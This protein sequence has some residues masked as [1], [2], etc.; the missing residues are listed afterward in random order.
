MRSTMVAILLVI[1]SSLPFSV[2]A[3][4][5]A[6]P[7]VALLGNV[8]FLSATR[9]W[10][11]VSTSAGYSL[12][13]YQAI[14]E[15]A[16]CH[17]AVTDIY[18]TANGGRTW[19]RI[20]RFSSTP[21]IGTA[22]PVA[23]LHAFDAQHILVVPTGFGPPRPLYWTVDGGRSWTRHAP[24][25]RLGYVTNGDIAS[26]G[27]HNLWMLVE[28]GAAMGSEQVTVYRSRDT[29]ARWIRAACT[30]FSTAAAA[31]QSS[32]LGIYGFKGGI[33]FTGP[34]T[35][36][37]VD[38]NNSG[39]PYLYATHDGGAHWRIERL[40]L[41]R[42][43]PAPNAAAD[44]FPYVTLAQ[45][46]FFGADGVLPATANVCRGHRSHGHT[47]YVCRSEFSLLLSKDRGLTWPI[48]RRLPLETSQLTSVVHQFLS[49]RT[50]IVDV[51]TTLRVTTDAG[52]HWAA[53]APA[54]IP[55]GYS[56]MTL[57]FVTRTN[58]WVIAARVYRP[59]DLAR[60]TL[61]MHTV[62]GGQDWQQVVVP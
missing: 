5:A 41:P 34:S 56:L 25:Q 30:A 59:D 15:P 60:S 43:V 2:L 16:A 61:L 36:F 54:G 19:R 52:R 22:L 8:T 46:H 26:S 3:S 38:N 29:G 53:I 11:E 58:G 40:G 4:S 49:A 62:D 21:F 44:R 33:V 47:N 13:C 55:H 17:R 1:A 6:P 27:R 42:G 39:I 10:L 37:M 32:G 50:W 12:F 45:P 35:G 28:N 14:P 7:E 31:C 48:T 18:A 51:G 9:G 57:R 20:L 23:R 24:P